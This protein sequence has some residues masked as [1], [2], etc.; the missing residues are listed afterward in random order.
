MQAKS[1]GYVLIRCGQLFNERGMAR[2]NAEAGGAMLREAHTRLLPHLQDPE[3]VRMTELARKLGVTK[4]AVQQLVSDM[5]EVG[6]VEVLSDPDDARA[7]RV[8]LTELGVGAIQHGTGLLLD[9]ERE[10]GRA[11]GSPKLRQL[12]SLLTELLPALEAK[13]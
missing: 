2:V 9:I 1:L 3:G 12:H 5:L 10:L 7:R 13:Q 4:Q 11:I 8:V 6:V